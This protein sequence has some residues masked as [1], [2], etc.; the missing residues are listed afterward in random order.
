MVVMPKLGKRKKQEEEEETGRTFKRLKN[1][2]SVIESNINE[3]ENGGL[4][5]CPDRGYH[6][7]KSY[8][9]LGVCA[10]NLKK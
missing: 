6:H 7:Y 3:L 8:I 2:H 10:Y 5:R 9:G 1:K 4:N